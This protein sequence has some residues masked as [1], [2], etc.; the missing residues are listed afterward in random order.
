MVQVKFECDDKKNEAN[1]KKHG[2]YLDQAISA[3][4]DPMRQEYYDEKHSSADENRLL[5]VGFAGNRPL[6]ISFTEPA[7]ETI[8]LI[9]ARRAKKHEQEELYYG[10][11]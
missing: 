3:F 1:F 7:P 2:V 8:R 5:L 9:S 4:D 11:R 10:N 6:L